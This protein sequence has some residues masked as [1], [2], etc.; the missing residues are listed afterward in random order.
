[1]TSAMFLGM[2]EARNRESQ[3]YSYSDHTSW[4]LVTKISL[5]ISLPD[6]VQ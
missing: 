3:K 6:F 5:F 4:S 2:A 1:M